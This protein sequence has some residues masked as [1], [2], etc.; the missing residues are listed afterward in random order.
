MA[1]IWSKSYNNC[2]LA[3]LG[4]S[5]S[6]PYQ[7]LLL[8]TSILNDRAHIWIVINSKTIIE[9]LNFWMTHGFHR[10]VGDIV[11][12][13]ED[14]A[15]TYGNPIH[16]VAICMVGRC[17]STVWWRQHTGAIYSRNLGTCWR[18][19]NMKAQDY[20]KMKADTGRQGISTAQEDHSPRLSRSQKSTSWLLQEIVAGLCHHLTV[21]D[22]LIV[23]GC[24]L[25]PQATIQDILKE[26]HKTAHQGIVWT[27][28]RG[29]LSVHSPGMNSDIENRVETR[30]GRPGHLG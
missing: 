1:N 6:F 23:Q 12:Y 20:K 13:N 11:I 28:Q 10:I 14:K 19:Q 3:T 2:N 24:C 4:R 8:S 27:T 25:L 18:L 16:G 21:D 26:L 7:S 17:T 5:H 30:L 9:W 22:G 15:S 29:W